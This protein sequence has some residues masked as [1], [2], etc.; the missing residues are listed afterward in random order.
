MWLIDFRIVY[1]LAGTAYIDGRTSGHRS[2]ADI[3]KD[4]QKHESRPIFFTMC[5]MGK[6]LNPS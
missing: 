1:A 3:P 6:S 2:S 4:N 5:G